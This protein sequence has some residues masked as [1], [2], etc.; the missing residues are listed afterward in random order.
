MQLDND[1]GL[2]DAEL[3]CALSEH[4]GLTKI[5]SLQTGA[6]GVMQQLRDSQQVR[7]LARANMHGMYG[8][9]HY[10]CNVRSQG[11]RDTVRGFID[12]MNE[13]KHEREGLMMI[14]V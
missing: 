11:M 6:A 8:L 14:S 7:A 4:G 2:L 3:D 9:L 1:V 5:L 12:R 13:M 10:R